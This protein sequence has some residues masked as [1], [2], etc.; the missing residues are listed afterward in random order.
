MAAKRRVGA[1]DHHEARGV[2]EPAPELL[3]RTRPCGIAQRRAAQH[4]EQPGAVDREAQEDSGVR[5]RRRH[6]RESDTGSKA[7]G[8]AD[9]MDH[10]VGTTLGPALSRVL[11]RGSVREG[12]AGLVHDHDARA[13]GRGKLV[14]I[15]A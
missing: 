7:A 12:D 8:D 2:I 11:R 13:D 1:G 10:R 3:E 4:G 5:T 15:A 9:D 14:L 6:D